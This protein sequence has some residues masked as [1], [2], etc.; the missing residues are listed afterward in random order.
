MSSHERKQYIDFT[1]DENA[2]LLQLRD[3]IGDFTLRS[4][5]HP[6]LSGE[7]PS[8]GTFVGRDNEL[9][10]LFA[11]IRGTD[12]RAE[13]GRPALHKNSVADSEC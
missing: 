2:A 11:M 7:P 4:S 10:K 8:G 3:R 13:T 6:R 9:Q 12:A 1:V 5:S